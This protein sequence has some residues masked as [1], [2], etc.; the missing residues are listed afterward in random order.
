MTPL[1][2]VQSQF[3]AYNAHD[4]DQFSANFSETFT[5]Y[6]MPSLQPSISGKAQLIH[7]YQTER[8][9]LPALRAELIARTVLGDKV[10]DHELI[11]GIQDKPIES[12]A[13]FHIQNSLIETAWFFFPE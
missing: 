8:F 4:I 5:A 2:R 13:V 3:A 7:F 12:I 6:R 1:E 9:N 10:F 11:Y